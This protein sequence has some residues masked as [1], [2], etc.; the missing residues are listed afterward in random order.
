MGGIRWYH[1]LVVLAAGAIPA[2]NCTDHSGSADAGDTDADDGADANGGADAGPPLAQVKINEVVLFPH[3]DW[4]DEG[5]TA[6]DAVPGPTLPATVRDQFVEL[7][8]AGNVALDLTGWTLEMIDPIGVVTD[9]DT[10]DDVVFEAG[11]SL[12]AFAP[13]TLLVIGDPAD[14]GSTD[15]Y[16]VL[17]DQYGR[18]VDDVEVGGLS[19]GRDMEGDGAGDGAPD[20]G[21]NGYAKGSFDEAVGRPV[22]AADTDD[23]QVDFIHLWASPL[24]PN[25]VDPPP[26]ESIAPQVVGYS[27]ETAKRISEAIRVE[28]DEIIDPFSVDAALRVE[29]GGAPVALGFA[30]FDLDDHVIEINTVGVLPFDADVFVTVQGGVD[31]VRDLAGN[32]LAADLT[33]SVHTENAPANPADVMVNEICGQ[34]LQDWDD[35]EGGDGVPFSTTPGTGMVD[36]DDEWL[37]LVNL[38]PGVTDMT[39]YTLIIYRGA[40]LISDP[41]SGTPLDTVESFVQVIGTG[42][43]IADVRQ[44]DRI[45]IGDPGG[46]M[47][48]DFW[49]ELRD[50]SGAVVDTIEVGGNSAGTDHGG[51]GV[52]NGAP[53]PG[54]DA[55]GADL[56]SECVARVPDLADSGDEDADFAH[57]AATLGTAN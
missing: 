57:T 52:D 34:P 9:L 8:N 43:G 55:T 36:S 56:S 2:C 39:S 44:N 23:D 50:D 40:N 6:F 22:G 21:K 14:R 28:L 38:R 15:V 35:T 45:I 5:G 17:R 20:P 19:V 29:V 26:V 42:T 37:E 12:T 30:T 33:F 46:A 4:S 18:V 16:I 53:G 13:G 48:P 32:P 11:S 54:Q 25:L 3:H 7:R 10:H 31:G 24:A 27:T 1:A 49:L 51:D 41:A 47:P